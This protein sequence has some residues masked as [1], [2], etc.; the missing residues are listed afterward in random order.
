MRIF[1]GK[2]VTDGIAA[3]R[4]QIYRK[5]KPRI[6]RETVSDTAGETARFKAAVAEAVLQI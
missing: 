2:S 1:R 4:L 3:G 6:S 5:E